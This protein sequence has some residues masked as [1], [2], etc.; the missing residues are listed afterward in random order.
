MADKKIDNGSLFREKLSAL[1]HDQWSGWMKHLFKQGHFN[2][3]GTWT[4][5]K[6]AAER[7]VRQMNN[8]YLLLSPDEQDSD[9]KEAD[10]FLAVIADGNA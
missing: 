3:D 1:C 9:R 7:W 4:M 10:K 2:S 6:W 5:P 8:H